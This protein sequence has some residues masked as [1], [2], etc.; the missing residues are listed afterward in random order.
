MSKQLTEVQA[1]NVYT[2]LESMVGA[3]SLDRD[4]FIYHHIRPD[5]PNV[6]RFSGKLGFGGKYWSDRNEVNCYSED[7]T[8]ELEQLIA[9]T[10]RVLA[11][12]IQKDNDI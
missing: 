2:V 6:W 4:N 7:E 5:G 12:V 1:K 3:I 8:P 10:N 11:T 9:R